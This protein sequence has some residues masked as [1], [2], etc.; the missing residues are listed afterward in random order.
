M[1]MTKAKVLIVEDDT[2]TAVGFKEILT[3]IGYTICALAGSGED[4]IKK[5]EL[6]QPDVVLMDIMLEGELGGVEAAD[7]IRARFDIPIIFLTSYI[8]E[9]LLRRARVTDPFGYLIK[10]CHPRELYATIELA[11]FKH[12]ESVYREAVEEELRRSRQELDTILQ[13]LAE[14]VTVQSPTGKLVYVN[15]VAA[16]QIGYASAADLM[17]VPVIELMKKFEI[18]H[19]D[20]RALALHELPGRRAIQEK[21]SIAATLRYL[22]KETGEERWSIVKSS[23][24]FHD[25][26]EVRLA[27]NVFHDITEQKKSDEQLGREH[28]F[29]RAVE[30]AV[31]SGIATVDLSGR[32][33]YVNPA[34][35]KMVGWTEAELVGQMPPY[36]YWP[37]DEQDNIARAFQTTINGEAPPHGF[38]VRFRRSNGEI[39]DA[40][41]VVSPLRTND[42]ELSGWLASITDITGR[43]KTEKTQRF[44]V[45][46]GAQIGSSLDYHVTLANVAKLAVPTLADWCTIDIQDETGVLQR[47]AVAHKD[48][49]KVHWV[50]EMHEH[51]PP[52][53]EAPYGVLHV[54]QTGKTE[55]FEKITGLMISE[56]VK[57]TKQLEILRELNPASVI[58][59]PLVARGRTLGAISLVTESERHFE[60][61]DVNV[62]EQLAYRAALAVDNSRL[63]R[64]SEL[65]INERRRVQEQYKVRAAQ[66]AAVADLGQFA[67]S[68]VEL[69]TLLDHAAEL[70]CKTLGVEFCKVLQVLPDAHKL[71]LRAGVGWRHGVV[72]IATLDADSGSQAGF[73]LKSNEPVIVRDLR[74]ETRFTGP[75][76]LHEHNVVSGLSVII[77]SG[78]QDWGV[79][80]AH[81]ATQRDFVEDDIN[82]VQS[83]ANVLAQAI[84]RNKARKELE[85]AYE[86]LE[87]RV[88]E[89]TASLVQANEELRLLQSLSIAIAESDSVPSALKIALQKICETTGWDLGRAWLPPA[90]NTNTQCVG[91]WSK[92][93]DAVKRSSETN[94]TLTFEDQSGIPERVCES[95][96]PV[97]IPDIESDPE[98][99]RKEWAQAI[100]LR[101]AMGVPILADDQVIAVLEFF[102]REPRIKDQ[103]LVGLVS[104]AAAQLGTVLQRKNVEEKLRASEM[105]LAEAQEVANIGSWKWEI[106]PNTLT[107]SDELY[108]IFGL[109]PAKFSVTFETYLSHVHPDDRAFVGKIIEQA[110][111]DEQQYT[112]RIIRQDGTQRIL[113]ARGKT[114]RDEDGKPVRMIGTGQ[115]ITER[116]LAEEEL[117]K[118]DLQLTTAQQI[119]HLGS[120]EYDLKS[121]SVTW[122]DELYRIYG[123]TQETFDGTIESFL[124]QV[125]PDDRAF[126]LQSVQRAIKNKEP[127]LFEERIIRPDGSVRA[128][129]SQGRVIVDGNGEVIQLIGVCLDITERKKAE[130]KFRGLLESAPDAIVI[131]NQSGDIVLVNAQTENVFGYS[132]KELLGQ[133]LELLLPQRLGKKHPPYREGR[134]IEAGADLK[135]IRKDGTEF[136]VEVSLSPLETE[137]GILISR[138]I[139]DITEQRRLQQQLFETERQRSADLRQYAI[140]IQRAQEEERQRISRELHD[141]L[142]Q[143]LSAMKLSTDMIEEDM[144][145]SNSKNA[146]ALRTFGKDIENII[147]EVRR[148]SHNLRPSALDDFGLVVA[149]KSL[150]QEFE[151]HHKIKIVFEGDDSSIIHLDSHIEIAV[152]RIVQESLSNI[153]KHSRASRVSIRLVQDADSIDLAVEDNGR[154]FEQ[155]EHPRL[156]GLYSGLGLISM[157]ERTEQLGGIFEISSIKKQ[158][159]TIHVRIPL[160][161]VHALVEHKQ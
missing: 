87:H 151:K 108:R 37:E 142:C 44:L 64:E 47:V 66:Q 59:A 128:L 22:N 98:F 97:W 56:S 139:R 105:E 28:A 78:S 79:L 144:P 65:E 140:L 57:K 58:I 75:S 112:F 100:D 31:S 48:P 55:F 115:D 88:K 76:L 61:S 67:L 17:K 94:L 114:I 53:I 93:A 10:P 138:A 80:S 116:R 42:V 30:A 7:Q 81:T 73:T 85:R 1:S 118:R 72:G 26:G 41:V 145:K 84:E 99:R 21:H 70:L 111:F 160:R 23:P 146:K 68:G 24:V 39:F 129:Q 134:P 104:A 117:Q 13:G 27:I 34:F 130:E 156:K 51:F 82:F 137:E 152:F 20:G 40:N 132:R 5:A 150:S 159:T 69:Q 36:K 62:A 38:E 12:Q 15:E 126:R 52:N 102:L 135:G 11:I 25:N 77:K 107:W 120:W 3:Q 122:S 110:S 86:V 96:K 119:A 133:P 149:L 35:C 124:E 14:G 16:R 95:R 143:R 63:Y 113:N 147:K 109:D 32:Q 2:L 4:A 29:R 157:R 121:G 45:E 158:G 154:G 131:V 161:E 153:A 43:K 74:K 71:L 127:F 83:L 90:E 106:A 125:H 19:E 89:R 92:T 6:H 141:D 50:E 60:E 136:P 103:R 33:T 101:G 91:S 8:D 123:L 49:S 148:M 9:A 54:I 46:A 18:T 155:E